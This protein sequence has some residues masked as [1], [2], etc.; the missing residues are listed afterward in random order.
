MKTLLTTSLLA[1]TLAC[2]VIA[3]TN[4]TPFP[5][6]LDL[7]SPVPSL[8]LEEAIQIAKSH[9]Q[10]KKIDTS[11]HYLDNVRLLYSSTW[12]KGK[13][14]IITWKLNEFADGGEIIIFVGM[15]KKTRMTYGK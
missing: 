3:Q 4:K 15:D 13:H 10:E 7:P 8:G 1:I 11:K 9:L 6:E 14:W 2:V 12:M 5:S